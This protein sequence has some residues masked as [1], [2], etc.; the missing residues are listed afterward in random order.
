M[1]VPPTSGVLSSVDPL[2]KRPTTF[3]RSTAPK[4]ND[5]SAWLETPTEKAQR[6]ADEVAG[7]KRKR[8][9]NV[10]AGR[11]D[12]EVEARRAR[13]REIKREVEKHN[14]CSGDDAETKRP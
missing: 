9:P 1:V 12:E 7:I 14:V 4:D 3:S 6:V 13:D 10:G 2:R 8:L 11:D 5:N